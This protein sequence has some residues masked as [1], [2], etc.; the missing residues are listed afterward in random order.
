MRV[1]RNNSVPPNYSLKNVFFLSVSS[2]KFLGAHI[3]SDLS[4]QTYTSY[5]INN[6]NRMLGFL[7]HN[8]SLAPFS[9]KLTSFKTLLRSKHEYAASLWDPSHLNLIDPLE[10][11]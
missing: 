8:F 5:V 3:S 6:A 1:S 4:W 10:P 7:K 9:L 2:Y 11:G